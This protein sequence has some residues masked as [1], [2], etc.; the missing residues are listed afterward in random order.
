MLYC[1]KKSSRVKDWHAVQQGW[2]SATLCGLPMAG[3][4][5]EWLS[6][7]P[8]G[9]ICSGCHQSI[10]SKNPGPWNQPRVEAATT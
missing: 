6:T 8:S 4:T 7:N 1:R 10:E 9:A 3:H 5:W 2:D